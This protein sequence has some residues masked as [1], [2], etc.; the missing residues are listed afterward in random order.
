MKKGVN[1]KN[2]ITVPTNVHTLE[3]YNPGT[4]EFLG[5]KNQSGNSRHYGQIQTTVQ[6][7][8]RE[9]SIVRHYH[10][11]TQRCRCSYIQDLVQEYACRFHAEWLQPTGPSQRRAEADL[12][13][14]GHG[15]LEGSWA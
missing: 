1:K 9:L 3:L 11:A 7:K 5:I 15:L 2:E 10:N 8:Q 13:W 12:K 14:G 4:E 6:S